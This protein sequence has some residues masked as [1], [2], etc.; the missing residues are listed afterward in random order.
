MSS[1]LAP[2]PEYKDSG[3]PWLGEIP[4]NWGVRRLKSLSP[5]KRGASPRPID[6]AKYFDDLGE[7]A[8]VRIADVTASTKSL[9]MKCLHNS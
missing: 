1:K 9:F 5:V 3:L 6:D 2:Y 4:V 7:Y 8:W